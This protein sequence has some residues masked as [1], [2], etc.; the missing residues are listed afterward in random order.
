[1]GNG[2]DGKLSSRRGGRICSKTSNT[3]RYP[4]AI[5]ADQYLSRIAMRPPM[6]PTYAVFWSGPR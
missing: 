2:T 5:S 1:M 6:T 4:D 3:T